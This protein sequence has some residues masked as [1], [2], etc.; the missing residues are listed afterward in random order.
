MVWSLKCENHFVWFE[1]ENQRQSQ[2]I[3][4]SPAYCGYELSLEGCKSCK[5]IGESKKCFECQHGYARSASTKT[6][7]VSLTCKLV[8]P[9]SSVS[10]LLL[11]VVCLICLIFIV[12]TGYKSYNHGK[13]Q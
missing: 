10:I 2:C 4:N 7:E 12:I 13:L 5:I 11:F 8:D 1:N 3:V 9:K 6:G